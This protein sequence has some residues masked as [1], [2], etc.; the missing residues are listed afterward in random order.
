MPDDAPRMTRGNTLSG[1]T[2][3][4]DEFGKGSETNLVV[5]KIAVPNRERDSSN[6]FSDAIWPMVEAASSHRLSG[7]VF[8]VADRT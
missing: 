1:A 5:S 7:G 2:P 3:I 4:H 8:R 6:P